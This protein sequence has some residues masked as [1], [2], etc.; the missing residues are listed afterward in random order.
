MSESPQTLRQHAFRI[1]VCLL[2][3]FAYIPIIMILAILASGSPDA[4]FPGMLA[5]M[6]ALVTFPFVSIGTWFLYRFKSF[7]IA[8]YC[9]ILLMMILLIITIFTMVMDSRWPIF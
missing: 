1:I 5:C 8:I 3:G 9:I 4:L 7:R 6:F 2:A